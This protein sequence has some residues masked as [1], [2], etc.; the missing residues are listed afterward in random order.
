MGAGSRGCADSRVHAS[1]KAHAGARRRGARQRGL[2]ERMRSW[3]GKA[4]A[5]DETIYVVIE[6]QDRRSSKIYNFK[7]SKISN[8]KSSTGK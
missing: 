5:G 7:L 2:A 3:G 8:M 6:T 1:N 4:R